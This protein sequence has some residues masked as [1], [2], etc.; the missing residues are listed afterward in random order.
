MDSY[1]KARLDR[2]YD[3]ISEKRGAIT[4]ADFED[5]KNGMEKAETR[6]KRRSA[7]T[8]RDLPEVN[9]ETGMLPDG[10]FVGGADRN[11]DRGKIRTDS[12]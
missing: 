3:E 7:L 4:R 11:A 9:P 5:R 1:L 8:S 12:S 2:F 10:T 6:R